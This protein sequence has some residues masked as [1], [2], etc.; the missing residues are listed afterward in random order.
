MK[1]FSNLVSL[2]LVVLI[3]L[4]VVN[5]APFQIVRVPLRFSSD[6]ISLPFYEYSIARK[7]K[8]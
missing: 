6:S 7:P 5:V 2:F 4:N 1:R 8:P 3:V